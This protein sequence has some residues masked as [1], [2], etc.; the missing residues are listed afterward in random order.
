M[1]CE[2]RVQL[3]FPH[4]VWCVVLFVAVSPIPVGG[5]RPFIVLSY[6]CRLSFY[7]YRYRNTEKKNRFD[8]FLFCRTIYRKLV[9]VRYSTLMRIPL[10]CCLLSSFLRWWCW[11]I[12]IFFLL[13]LPFFDFDLDIVCFHPVFLLWVLCCLLG[14]GFCCDSFRIWLYFDVSWYVRWSHL[15]F[16]LRYTICFSYCVYYLLFLFVFLLSRR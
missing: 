9:S 14:F 3:C 10:A 8:N 16:C 4:S 11:L 7:R 13:F 2:S 15:L 5:V 1:T 12:F 6:R